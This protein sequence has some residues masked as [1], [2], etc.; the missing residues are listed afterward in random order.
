MNIKH[1]FRFLTMLL[2][3]TLISLT[4]RGDE[5][6]EVII[7]VKDTAAIK[8]MIGK[9]VI[10][11]G[12]VFNAAWSSSGKVLNIEFAGTGEGGFV[13][14][15]FEKSRKK[16]DDAFGGDFAK[17]IK[18]QDVHLK[19][20]V[21][22]SRAKTKQYAGRPQIVIEEPGQITIQQPTTQPS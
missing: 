15:A 19:G 11:S 12:H 14:V 2:A 21:E 5:P 18:D 16:L 3:L 1:S 6:K 20:R 10:V 17:A 7:D 9:H 8:A 4:A 13:A 22:E